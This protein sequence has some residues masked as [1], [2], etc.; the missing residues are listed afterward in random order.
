MTTIDEFLTDCETLPSIGPTMRRK[1]VALVRALKEQRDSRF[2]LA[3]AGSGDWAK[4]EMDRLVAEKDAV[5]ARMDAA[6][7]AIIDGEVN[8]DV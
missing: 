6:L 5:I 1:L 8:P 4:R 2:P 3:V 7:L